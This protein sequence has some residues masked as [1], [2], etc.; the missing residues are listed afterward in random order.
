MKSAPCHLIAAANLTS[1]Y[2]TPKLSTAL[3]H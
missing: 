2:L 3:G 1:V